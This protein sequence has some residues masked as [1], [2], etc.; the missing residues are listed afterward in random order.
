[1]ELTS[2]NILPF[3]GHIAGLAHESGLDQGLG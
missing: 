2:L 1:M 3:L